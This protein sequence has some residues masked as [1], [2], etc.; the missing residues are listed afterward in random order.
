MSRAR[1]QWAEAGPY[2]ALMARTPGVRTRTTRI[3]TWVTLALVAF[4]GTEI[5]LAATQSR[6]VPAPGPVQLLH[7]ALTAA[8]ASD[9]FHYRAVWRADGVSQTVVGDARSSSGSESVSVGGDRFTVVYTG[10]EAYFEGGSAALRDQLG[11]AAP[12]ASVDAGKW[13]S[14]QPSDGPYPSIEEGVTTSAALAQVLIAPSAT[15][16][17]HQTN[18]VLLSRITGRIPHGRVVTG[19]ARLD[20]VSR[21][22]LPATYAAH[23]S[24]GAQSWSS[25]ITFSRWGENNAIEAPAVALPFASLQGAAPLPGK[26]PRT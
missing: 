23:G 12:T 1:S 20:L 6:R 14:L 11:L 10:E 4:L 3:A 25:T 24:G 19:W 2:A 22:K 8:G 9:A 18:G 15:S 13:I 26:T 5:G 17:A 21:S 7:E 16:P